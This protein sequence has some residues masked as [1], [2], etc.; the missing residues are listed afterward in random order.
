MFRSA[1]MSEEG[2]G[3][4]LGLTSGL[5]PGSARVAL[6]LAR[7]TGNVRLL[8]RAALGA[9]SAPIADWP[10]L[11]GAS[12]WPCSPSSTPPTLPAAG[13][14]P[15]AEGATESVVGGRLGQARRGAA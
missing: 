4:A 2:L 10:V 7:P 15:R 9:P 6:R 5:R 13:R 14:G 3:R 11:L 1:R 8:D 12:S